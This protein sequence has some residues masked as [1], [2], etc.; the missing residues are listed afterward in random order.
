VGEYIVIIDK[1]L[2]FIEDKQNRKMYYRF[3]PAKNPKNAPILVILHGHGSTRA[4]KF[5][6]PMWNVLAP[7]DHYGKDS[8]GSWWLG[9]NEDFFVKE[10]LHQLI[11]KIKEDTGTKEGLYFWGSSMGG[12][13]ALLHGILLHAHAIYANV[14]QIKLLGTTYSKSKMDEYFKF[15]IQG[16]EHKYN[17]ITNFLDHNLKDR[18]TF[19]IAQ[20]KYDYQ[21]YLKEHALYFYDK[22]K[23][24]NIECNIEIFNTNEHKLLLPVHEAVLKLRTNYL[25]KVKNISF[26][27]HGILFKDIN[28]YATFN[29]LYFDETSLW[30]LIIDF[31][32]YEN[33]APINFFFGERGSRFYGF[34]RVKDKIYYRLGS[35]EYIGGLPYH[36]GEYIKLEVTYDHG[37]WK[38]SDGNNTVECDAPTKVMFNAIGSGYNGKEHEQKTVISYVSISEYSE[39]QNSFCPVAEWKLNTNYGCITFDYSGN[40]RHAVLVNTQWINP[41]RYEVDLTC[42]YPLTQKEWKNYTKHT[43]QKQYAFMQTLLM[44]DKEPLLWKSLHPGIKNEE[45]IQKGKR[46]LQNIYQFDR[47]DA[48]ELSETLTWREDP[49]QNRSWQ[50]Q[51][52]QFIFYIHLIAAYEDTNDIKYLDKLVEVVQSWYKHSYAEIYPSTLTWNDHTTA[53]RLRSLIHIWEYLKTKHEIIDHEIFTMILNLIETHCNVLSSRAFYNKHNNH[54]FD[55]SLFLYWASMLYPEFENAQQWHDIGYDRLIDEIGVAFTS[56]GMHIEN[57]PSY[58]IGM[59]QRIDIAAKVMRTYE[60]K[61]IVDI[62]LI[63]DNALKALAYLLH[64]DGTLP[65]MGDTDRG[66]RVP[67]LNQLKDFSNFKLFQYVHSKGKMGSKEEAPVDVVFEESGYAVFRDRWHPHESYSQTVHCVF[68]CSFISTFHRHDDDLNFVLQAYGEEWFVDGGIYKYDEKDPYR[69]YLRSAKAHNIP[70]IPNIQAARTLPDS[71]SK[72][73]RITAYGLEESYAWVE[74]VSY[75]YPGYEVKRKLEYHKPTRFMITDSVRKGEEC[76]ESYD[77]M[78]HIPMDKEIHLGDNSVTVKSKSGHEFLMSFMGECIYELEVVTG[79]EG[80]EVMGWQ[81]KQFNVLEPVQVLI[82]HVT[83]KR[84]YTFSSMIECKFCN[85]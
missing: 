17:D 60:R 73:S 53:L 12:F 47:F 66:T 21:D 4:S 15:V 83:S 46:I 8:L 30:K 76:V 23:Q 67:A 35:G 13:G 44:K 61:D 45:N 34:T 59:L 25:C 74:A 75:M 81:A 26:I 55:Q 33:N 14:P 71:E 42:R 20:S 38:F 16:E 56:E 19:Y 48:V 57:S 2:P 27:E 24:Y 72:R 11:S 65:M 64:P 69:K 85:K 36:T 43:P 63:I 7:I 78:F 18:I 29:T 10:L 22:C 70:V 79:K 5:R 28:S 32:E 50:W 52:Q 49:F 41:V 37:H 31:K 3:T 6:D 40:H 51:Y 62:D 58:L 82:C 77:L 84:E 80:E 1:T 68:K 54:G 39:E 9:E